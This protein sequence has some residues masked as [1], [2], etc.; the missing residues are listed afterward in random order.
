MTLQEFNQAM[1]Y[2]FTP[3]VTDFVVFLRNQGAHNI[4]SLVEPKISIGFH[5]KFAM[6]TTFVS[7]VNTICRDWW[8]F[9]LGA[10]R[11]LANST[12]IMYDDLELEVILNENINW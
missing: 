2:D 8:A 11:Y 4:E 3:S 5:K 9:Y 7:T 10:V 1:E 12:S 6:D